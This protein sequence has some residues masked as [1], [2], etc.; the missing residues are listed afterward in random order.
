MKNENKITKKESKQLLNIAMKYI[1]AMQERGDFE[2]RMNDEEDFLDVSV[3]SLEAA[4][5]AAYL[6]GKNVK[7]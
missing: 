7:A 3:G 6:L 2:Y 4:L 5:E 1:Y